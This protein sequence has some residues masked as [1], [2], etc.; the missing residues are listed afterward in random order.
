MNSELPRLIV[1]GSMATDVGRVRTRNEDSV[2]YM[3]PSDGDVT[4]DC[5]L[6]AVVADGVGGHAAGDVASRLATE[7]VFGVYSE[8]SGR[9]ETV[10]LACLNAANAAILERGASDPQCE[11]MATTCTVLLL[12]E[13]DMCLAH[14]G[15]SRA[16]RLRGGELK[17]VSED[18]SLVAEMVREGTMAEEEAELNPHR[19]VILRALG[20]E[21][22]I[23]PMLL[24]EPFA[25]GDRFVLCSDGLSNVVGFE[26]IRQ[27][28]SERPPA[29][30]CRAMIDAALEGGAPDN[31]SVGVFAIDRETVVSEREEGNR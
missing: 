8:L 31:V 21:S 22:A 18:H 29:E 28:V 13:A 27:I 25:I 9:A 6:L 24:R 30:A 2:S 3:I 26:T 4:P 19:N 12:T 7:T 16:Y 10:L 23:D 15:D 5:R 14:I 20:A 1:T 11:G 17:Q